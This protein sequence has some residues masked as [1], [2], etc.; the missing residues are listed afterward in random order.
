MAWNLSTGLSQKLLAGDLTTT[1]KLMADTI[2]TGS[3]D[4]SGGTDTINNTAGLDSF[5]VG[6][7]LLIQ[8]GDANNNKAVKALTVTATVIEVEAGSLAA[9]AAG[10]V[11]GLFKF[12]P[13]GT[14]KT[15][16]ANSVMAFF[17][18]QRP[19]N[20]DMAEP[21]SERLLVTL[22]G[23][24]FVPGVS[25]NGLNMGQLDGTTMK[26]AIDPVTGASEVWQGTPP[27]DVTI[28]SCRWYANDKVTGASV[29][30]IR[31]DGIV[32]TS[33]GDVNFV[34]GNSLVSGIPATVSD[35]SFSL[36]G[37]N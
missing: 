27:T 36:R 8:S 22:N 2:S 4:G 31:M 17:T 3:G 29:S 37:I 32:S 12:D 5:A 30:A 25:T 1:N 24:P 26:R 16:F 14:I 10:A 28:S 21:G 35:V 33:G 11:I 15:L 23:A 6:D 19:D 18:E 20:A 7:Y 9:V 34:N 13:T